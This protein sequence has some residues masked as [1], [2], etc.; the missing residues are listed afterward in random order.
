MSSR[1]MVAVAAAHCRCPSE[2]PPRRREEDGSAWAVPPEGCIV[3]SPTTAPPPP[4]H[5]PVRPR[6]PLPP[7]PSPPARPRAGP[8]PVSSCAARSAP[9]AS[10]STR[11]PT[12]W[13]SLPRRTRWRPR[14]S[15]WRLSTSST[16]RCA[17]RTR[18]TP[19]S[20]SPLL[21]PPWTPWSPSWARRRHRRLLSWRAAAAAA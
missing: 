19:P 7:T 4:S 13:P 11:W 17:R 3:L 8:R 21:S 18:P 2:L 12:P 10:T 5:L 15:S 20:T 1:R 14:R 16:L 6:D 9:C